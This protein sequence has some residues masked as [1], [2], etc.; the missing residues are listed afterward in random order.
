MNHDGEASLGTA[1]RISNRVVKALTPL[2]EKVTEEEGGGGLMLL[3]TSLVTAGASLLEGVIGQAKTAEFLEQLT[4][5]FRASG[6]ESPSE[7]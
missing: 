2:V 1:E 3:G 6:S 5:K 7:S 4:A